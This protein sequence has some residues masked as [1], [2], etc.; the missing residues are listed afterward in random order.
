MRLSDL[1]PARALAAPFDLMTMLAE[2]VSAAKQV[3]N[4][5]GQVSDENLQ[6]V[7][8]AGF[9]DG[10]VAEIIAHVAINVFTN[11]FNIATH[12]DIDFPKVSSAKAA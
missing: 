8:K 4:A 7:R 3:L 12:V 11:Y 9:S 1:H 5:K 2:V 6:A 10:E